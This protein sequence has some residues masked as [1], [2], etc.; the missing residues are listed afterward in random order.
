MQ[1]TTNPTGHTV[2]LE[3]HSSGIWKT[4]GI[5]AATPVWAPVFDNML[6]PGIGSIAQPPTIIYCMQVP[7]I[8]L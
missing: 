7:G 3:T 4:N 2:W 6:N 1:N 5:S 8:Y